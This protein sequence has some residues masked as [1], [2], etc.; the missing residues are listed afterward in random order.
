[1][2]QYL[3]KWDMDPIMFHQPNLIQTGAGQSLLGDLV[4]KVLQKYN[5][6]YTLPIRNL[7]EHEI[8]LK[9]ADRMRFN[10]AKSAGL[11]AQM[12][13]CGTPNASPTITL[14]SPRAAVI[15]VT[16]V[17]FGNTVETYGGQNISNISLTAGQTVVVPLTCP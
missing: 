10:A 17:R 1:M 2:V 5:S 11:T 4:N 8:G 6:M 7:R 14:T 13:P 16:G 3:L 15:P 12:V 9:M